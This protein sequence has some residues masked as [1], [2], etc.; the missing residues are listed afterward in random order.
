[1]LRSEAVVR[2][3]EDADPVAYAPMLCAGTAVF[4]GMRKMGI[5]PGATVGEY[6]PQLR[7][8]L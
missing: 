6:S 4:N 1:V 5:S 7:Y 8:F 3:P 2:I